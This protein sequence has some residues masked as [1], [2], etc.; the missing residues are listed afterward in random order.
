MA[1]GMYFN[2]P[3]MNAQQYD[4][5]IRRLE[6]AGQG[7]PRGRQYHVCFGTGDKLQVFDVWESQESFEAFGRTLMPLLQELGLSAGEP[8]AEP[9]HNVI[10]GEH[11]H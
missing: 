3:S 4:E 8:T 5:T 11:H 7:S 2:P 1:I 6:A 10:L 9:V